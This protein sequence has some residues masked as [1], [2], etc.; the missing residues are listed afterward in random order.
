[1]D[2]V[3]Q[4]ELYLQL[5]RLRRSYISHGSME[6]RDSIISLLRY[7]KHFIAKVRP[8]VIDAQKFLKASIQAEVIMLQKTPDY[9]MFKDHKLTKWKNFEEQYMAEAKAQFDCQVYHWTISQSPRLILQLP[10]SS[11]ARKRHAGSLL[12]PI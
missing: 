11:Y 3:D 4:K 1:M 2:S 8:D 6:D 7:K 5:K 9:A 12:Y 10:N